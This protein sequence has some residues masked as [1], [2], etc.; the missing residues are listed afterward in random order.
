MSPAVLPSLP[1]DCAFASIC[2]C[3]TLCKEHSCLNLLSNLVLLCCLLSYQKSISL[4]FLLFFSFNFAS[5]VIW[6]PLLCHV[7][8]FLLYIFMLLA[9]CFFFQ[10]FC[11]CL[12]LVCCLLCFPLWSLCCWLCVSLSFLSVLLVF[13]EKK[14]QF[15][16][17]VDGE[18][19]FCLIQCWFL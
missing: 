1:S 5:D 2:F 8:V 16:C 6:L 9:P 14:V 19:M 18:S 13:P 7:F 17:P 10:C 3:S 12:Q 15:Q 11:Y 4:S